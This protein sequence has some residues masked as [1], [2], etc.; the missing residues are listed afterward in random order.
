[1]EQI[2]ETRFLVEL[3]DW[4]SGVAR[5]LPPI[6]CVMGGTGTGKSTIFNSL[7]SSD[8]SSV[9]VKRPCTMNA[10]ILANASHRDILFQ[11][12]F[13]FGGEE[14]Q[15]Q[16]ITQPGDELNSFILVDTLILTALQK[17]TRL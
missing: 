15:A 12:P 7:V 11:A 8:I 4:K 17:V 14:A 6:V 16:L 3:F 10:I 2:E 5:N 9:S 13:V 1:M